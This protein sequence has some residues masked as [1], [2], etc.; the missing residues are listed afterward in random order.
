MLP[1]P[2]FPTNSGQLA[3]TWRGL[4]SQVPSSRHPSRRYQFY[5]DL[6]DVYRRMYARA[7]RPAVR[8]A[9]AAEGDC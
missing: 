8:E 3:Q 2:P 7:A 9:L 5:S 6:E 4:V 1:R